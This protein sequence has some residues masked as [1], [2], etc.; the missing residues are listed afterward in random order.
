MKY[1]FWGGCH[2]E[3]EKGELEI[4]RFDV[5][6]KHDDGLRFICR[7]AKEIGALIPENDAD[8]FFDR[9]DRFDFF[10]AD[11]EFDVDD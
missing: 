3:V 10:D 11:D 9:S 8:D 4:I 2:C 7:E 5:E 1:L 6:D